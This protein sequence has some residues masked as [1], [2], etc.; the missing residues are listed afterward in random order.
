MLRRCLEGRN[1]SFRRVRPS[2][3]GRQSAREQFRLKNL[4]PKNLLRLFLAEVFSLSE[5]AFED[6]PKINFSNKHIDNLT[7]LL[8]LLGLFSPRERSIFERTPHSRL[9]QDIPSPNS[10]L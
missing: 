10:G 4:N 8:L 7:R 2:P 9:R 5:F 1:T 3:T 6:P